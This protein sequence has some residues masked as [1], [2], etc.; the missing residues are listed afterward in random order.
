EPRPDGDVAADE[1]KMLLRCRDRSRDHPAGTNPG[2][3]GASLPGATGGTGGGDLLR[4]PPGTDSRAHLRRAAL[5]RAN[6]QDRDD[7]GRFFRRGSG[8]TAARGSSFFA[9]SAGGRERAGNE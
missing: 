8:G 7:H 9:P 6:A 5:S 4:R 2:R 1:T 3:Y